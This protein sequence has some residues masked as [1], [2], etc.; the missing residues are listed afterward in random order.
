M[1][2]RY[3]V[4][5]SFAGEERELVEWIAGNPLASWLHFPPMEVAMN[6]DEGTQ[7][8]LEPRRSAQ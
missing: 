7:E 8:P 3:D 1:T 4:A 5:L 2:F 6:P